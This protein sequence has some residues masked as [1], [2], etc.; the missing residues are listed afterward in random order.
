MGGWWPTLY[1]SGGQWG[2]KACQRS[3]Q[4]SSKPRCRCQQGLRSLYRVTA[5]RCVMTW[6]WRASA[7]CKFETG[8]RASKGTEGRWQLAEVWTT[9]MTFLHECWMFHCSRLQAG[10]QLP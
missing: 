10:V 8:K 4:V 7:P 6:Q 3:C 5:G 1:F 2:P 9:V